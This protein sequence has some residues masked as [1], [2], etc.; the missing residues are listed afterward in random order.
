MSKEHRMSEGKPGRQRY[1]VVV[2]G[3]RCAGAATALLLARRGL[4]V[5]VLDRGRYG[6]D[7]LSTHALMRGAVLQ[8][9]RFGV[10]PAIEEAGTPLV[11]STSFHYGDEEVRV[12][13]KAK[14]GI[15]GLFA[16]RRLLLDRA[17][18]DAA[19]AAG[20]EMVYGLRVADLQRRADGRVTGVVAEDGDGNASTLAADLVVGADGLHSTVARRAGAE[21]YRRGG[22]ATGVVFGYFHGLEADGYHW[23]FCSTG[24]AGRIPTNDG[25]TC[26]FAT[27]TADRFVR[28]I[29]QDVEAGFARVLAEC[30]PELARAVAAA[31]RAGGLRG[32]AGE[33]GFMRQSFGGGFAL[34][35]DAGYFKDPLTAHG[36]TDALRD[37]ELLADAVAAGS[38]RALQEYQQT[39]DDLG[40]RLFELTDRIAS[41]AWTLSELRELHLALSEEMKREVSCLEGRHGRTPAAIRLSA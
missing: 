29:R 8:L 14:G 31:P 28:E 35:G 12:P 5:L 1:D 7:T 30:S 22:H 34:V 15:P 10:L 21:S 36:I 20:A 2:A 38:G 33:L 13:V 19:R 9:Q 17:L 24:S 11:T 26:V 18:V 39:R 27:T 16:P 41:F 32:F 37:A 23:H 25:L 3:A 4:R 40:L 6:T